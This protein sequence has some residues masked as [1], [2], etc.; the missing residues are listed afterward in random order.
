MTLVVKV[1][2]ER[3]TLLLQENGKK[4]IACNYPDSLEDQ[5]FYKAQLVIL[6]VFPEEKWIGYPCKIESLVDIR[7][8]NAN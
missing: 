3:D 6:Q 5:K 2:I 8:F 1:D 7:G 4:Y